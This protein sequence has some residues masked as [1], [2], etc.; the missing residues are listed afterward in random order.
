MSEYPLPFSI[1]L[2]YLLEE[3]E[4]TGLSKQCRPRSD[5]AEYGNWSGSKVIKLFF[6]LK[7]VKHEIFTANK[8]ENANNSW[9]FH[10]Y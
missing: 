7:S 1:Q 10:I 5:V 6:M 2:W 4:P 8:Y 3:L 9:L